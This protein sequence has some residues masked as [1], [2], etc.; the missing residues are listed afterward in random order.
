[1]SDENIFVLLAGCLQEGFLSFLFSLT[2]LLEL[3]YNSINSKNFGFLSPTWVYLTV[4]RYFSRYAN[5]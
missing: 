3:I 4:K 5:L 1:M 2:E